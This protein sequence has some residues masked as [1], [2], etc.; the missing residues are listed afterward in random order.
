MIRLSAKKQGLSAMAIASACCCGMSAY[1]A[2]WSVEPSVA[3]SALYNDNIRFAANST[4]LN[5]TPVRASSGASIAPSL[6]F[7]VETEVR[8][9]TGNLRVATNYYNNDRDLNSNDLYFNFGWR[10]KGERSEFSLVSNNSFDSTLASLLQDVGNLTDRKQRQKIS[11]NPTY[12]YNISDRSTLAMGY[13]FEDVSFR[14]A[15]NTAL[16]DYRSNEL[17]P[18]LRYKLDEKN[19]L[20]FN[21]NLWQ[22]ITVPDN[23]DNSRSTFKTGLLN[24]LYNQALTETNSWSAGAGVYAVDESTPSSK[25]TPLERKVRF[26][27]VTALAK[28]Q[29]KYESSAY[30]ITVAREI[31]PSGENTLLRTNRIGADYTQGLSPYLSAG[32]SLGY[33]KNNSLGGAAEKDGQY[34]RATPTLSWKPA[35]EWQIEGGASYQRAKSS[36]APAP[37]ITATAKSAFVNFIYFWNKTALSR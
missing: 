12:S 11:V 1:G 9:A 15:K 24:V 32:I 30:S 29:Q 21:A 31:N 22:L 25:N 36:T 35:R 23:S 13:R 7:G 33:Y 5:A 19:D 4:A 18:S 37:E 2:E 34:F 27:G 20:L 3:V 17:L 14:D 10:E 28:Y 8:K 16:V 6:L 26:N